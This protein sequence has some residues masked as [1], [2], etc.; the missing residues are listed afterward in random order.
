MPCNLHSTQFSFCHEMIRSVTADTRSAINHPAVNSDQR[1][2]DE[3]IRRSIEPHMFHRNQR[4]A[5]GKRI[6]Q[7]L[8]V[9]GLLICTPSCMRP[10][11]FGLMAYQELKNLGRWCARKGVGGRQPCMN[12]TRSDRLL[13]LA[14]RSYPLATSRACVRPR[15]LAHRPRSNDYSQQDSARM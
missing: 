15:S 2:I 11:A 1:R 12:R 8:F 10:A 6:P 3:R 4:A 13:P 7:R 14:K 5:P 9:G